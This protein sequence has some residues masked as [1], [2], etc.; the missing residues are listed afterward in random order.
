MAKLLGLAWV[1]HNG[2]LLRSNE[3]AKIDLGGPSRE[4]V[5][6]NEVHGHFSKIMPGRVECEIP[7]AKGDS[8]EELRDIEDATITFECDTG[9]TY[10]IRNAASLTPPVIT[11]GGG[12]AIPVVFEGQPAER[13]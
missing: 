11:A 12:G 6:G 8:P 2:K 5:T 7:L 9:Q 13:A 1:R 3:G 10:I 4:T